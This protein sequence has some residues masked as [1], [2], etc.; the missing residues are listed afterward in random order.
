LSRELEK[1]LAALEEE[2]AAESPPWLDD[3]A[4]DFED[5][6][7]RLAELL[8]DDGLLAAVEALDTTLGMLR[9]CAER[10]F[11]EGTYAVKWGRRFPATLTDFIARLPS[12]ERRPVLQA[13][14]DRN[15]PL[16]HWLQHL[17]DGKSTLPDAVSE[18]TLSSLVRVYLDHTEELY[19]LNDVCLGCSLERP[20]RN[21]LSEFFAACP[22]CGRKECQSV[23]VREPTV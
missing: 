16:S 14:A 15:H 11:G 20:R 6:L 17:A 5:A 12:A 8:D 23:N 3:A 21:D 22:N 18:D 7:T 9:W 10:N 2:Q 4:D 13:L 1:R 19:F